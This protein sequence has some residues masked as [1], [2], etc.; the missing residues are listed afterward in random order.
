MQIQEGPSY[1]PMQGCFLAYITAILF[2][3]WSKVDMRIECPRNMVVFTYPQHLKHIIINLAINASTF[4]EYHYIWVRAQIGNRDVQVCVGD[5]GAGIPGEKI[6]WLFIKFQESL[7]LLN[8]GTGI[9]LCLWK[10]LVELCWRELWAWQK[11]VPKQNQ[12]LSKAMICSWL[13]VLSSELW[14]QWARW[15]RKP[16]PG[17]SEWVLLVIFPWAIGKWKS[18]QHDQ[19]SSW[20]FA[21]PS[22]ESVCALHRWWP[23]ALKAFWKVAWKGWSKLEC[24]KG[25]QWRNSSASCSITGFWFFL[26]CPVHSRH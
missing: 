23:C 21:W 18:Q 22:R 7:D 5:S 26:S 8:Q 19:S 25:S 20:I 12:G 6:N 3:R 4:V 24:S 16:N 11:K 9:G 2:L 14:V 1:R 13:E 10:H 15:W 17:N